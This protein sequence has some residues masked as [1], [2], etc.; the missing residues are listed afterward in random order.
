M[1]PFSLNN[2]SFAFEELEYIDKYVLCV[3][4]EELD[5]CIK[6]Y[7]RYDFV[8]VTNALTTFIST[9]F[10]SFYMDYTKDI[11]YILDKENKRRRQVQSVIYTCVDTL[12]KLL[13]PILS[14]TCE[15]VYC[16]FSNF[17]GVFD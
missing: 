13:A 2:L 4:N 10:S 15:E 8:S 14:F 7:Q 16:N 3:L 12:A 11:L 1:K 5:E 6:A 9:T 17:I